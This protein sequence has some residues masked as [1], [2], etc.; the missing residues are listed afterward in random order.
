VGG[1]RWVL[2]GKRESLDNTRSN[3]IP[4]GDAHRGWTGAMRNFREL[5]YGEVRRTYLLGTPVKRGL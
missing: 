2:Q 5:R 1:L 3:P 4:C